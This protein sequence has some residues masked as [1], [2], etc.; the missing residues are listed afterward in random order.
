[1]IRLDCEQGSVEWF[2]ARLGLPTASCFD[3]IITNKTGKLSAS[4]DKYAFQLLAEQSLG[5]ALDNSTSGFMHRGT[6]LE[7]RAA[8]YYEMLR[9]VDTERVGFV[10]RDDRRVGGSPDRFVGADGLLEIKCPSAA[11][12]VGYLLDD[13]GIGYRTQVQG[14]LWLCEREWSDTLSYHP[15]MPSALVRQ[16]RDE[17]FIAALASAVDQFLS[18][19]DESKLRLQRLGMFPDEVIPSLK[20]A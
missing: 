1:M 7:K 3:Q 10:L 13:Q 18:F 11:V 6:L 12:H 8:D 19:M 2:A 4:S 16:V 15:D 17:P 20:I 14:Q 9:D 5:I